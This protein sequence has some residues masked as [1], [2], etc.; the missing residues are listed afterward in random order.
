MESAPVCEHPIAQRPL[1]RT[2]DVAGAMILRRMLAP[3]TRTSIRTWRLWVLLEA[4]PCG[5]EREDVGCSATA[6]TVVGQ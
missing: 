2:V 6:E 1:E 4:V 5:T 3:R